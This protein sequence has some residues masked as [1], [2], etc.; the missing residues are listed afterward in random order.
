MESHFESLHRAQLQAIGFPPAL[1]FRLL[2]KLST[3]SAENIEGSFQLCLDEKGSLSAC[4]SVLKCSRPL[5]ALSDVFVLQHIWESDGGAGAKGEL[6]TDPG[7]L[8]KV[9]SALGIVRREGEE[10]GE[11]MEGMVRIVCE[12]SGKSKMVA[13][14]ALRESGFDLI[15]GIA[16]SRQLTEEDVLRGKRERL[17]LTM[18]EFRRGLD[19]ICGEKTADNVPEAQI[20]AMYEDWKDRKSREPMRDSENWVHCSGYQWREEEDKI[21]TVAIPL[22]PNMKKKDISSDITSRQWKFGVRGEK[23]IIDGEFF[24]HVVPDECFWTMEEGCVSV[25]VQ[26]CEGGWG[27]LIVGEV[28]GEEGGKVE[29]EMVVMLRVD[30]VMTRMWHVNQTYTAVTHEGNVYFSPLKS[31]T[32]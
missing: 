4:G 7:L 6:L 30:E 9:E 17:A 8:A 26:M 15:A 10:V 31:L 18:D 20:Q 13:W 1:V 29:E 5:P 24:G 14:K 3:G 16:L 2:S 19:G 12:Q 21:I 25:S 22:P 23:R 32:L 11:V 28:Q 27:E